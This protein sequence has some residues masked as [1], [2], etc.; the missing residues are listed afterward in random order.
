MEIIGMREEFYIGEH[1][2]GY[3]CEFEGNDV[4]KTRH[5]LLVIEDGKKFEI[6]LWQEEGQCGSGWATATW[7]RVSI[8]EVENFKGYTYKPKQRLISESKINDFIEHEYIGH[9]ICLVLY[10][11]I[12]T[13]VFS[14]SYD[15]GDVYY[16][17]LIHI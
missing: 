8:Q 13:D 16:L 3:N 2:T 15:N 1:I 10:N 11:D 6:T 7:G 14:V 12:K 4:S 9:K 5:I 17:S